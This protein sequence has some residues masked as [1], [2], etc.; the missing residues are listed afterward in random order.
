MFW[1]TLYVR[2]TVMRPNNIIC[3]SYCCSITP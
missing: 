1:A 3:L 2:S